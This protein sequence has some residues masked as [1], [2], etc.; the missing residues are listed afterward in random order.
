MRKIFLIIVL[1]FLSKT[2]FEQVHEEYVEV[3]VE[4]SIKIDPEII[5]YTVTLEP[6]A[7]TSIVD[8]ASSNSITETSISKNLQ[9]NSESEDR[10]RELRNLIKQLKIDTLEVPVNTLSNLYSKDKSQI[11]LRFKSIIVF[12]K[13]IKELIK[14]NI[15]RGEVTS[16]QSSQKEKFYSV[17][18]KKLIQLANINARILADQCNK[19][20]GQIIQVKEE[21]IFEGGWTAYPPLGGLGDYVKMNLD[22]QILIQK[23]FIVRYS[24]H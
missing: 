18:S 19:K 14:L 5:E 17:L 13:F 8:S 1:F 2:S 3:I 6:Y 4:D 21:K 7:E 23:R 24:W 16:I 10:N 9:L 22:N 12:N 11:T 20:L 15:S